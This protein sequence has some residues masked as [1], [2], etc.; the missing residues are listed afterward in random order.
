MGGV[1]VGAKAVDELEDV[2]G[3]G[4]DVVRWIAAPMVD[5]FVSSF[6]LE[7]P[8]HPVVFAIWK[9]GEIKRLRAMA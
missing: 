3:A 9:C 1:L 5:E 2:T 4:A 8:V 7:L 6:I